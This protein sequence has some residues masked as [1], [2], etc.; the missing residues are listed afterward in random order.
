MQ[1]RRRTELIAQLGEHEARQAKA[2]G[3]DHADLHGAQLTAGVSFHSLQSRAEMDGQITDLLLPNGEAIGLRDDRGGLR[4]TLENLRVLALDISQQRVHD[5]KMILQPH[6]R[7]LQMDVQPVQELLIEAQLR[8]RTAAKGCD[9][10]VDELEDIRLIDPGRE[11]ILRI[12][13]VADLGPLD[14]QQQIGKLN[15][16]H[17]QLKLLLNSSQNALGQFLVLIIGQ[18]QHIAAAVRECALPD[19]FDADD[20]VHHEPHIR[21]LRE[22]LQPHIAE[23]IEQFFHPANRIGIQ[24]IVDAGRCPAHGLPLRRK[25]MDEAP[26]RLAVIGLAARE[27]HAVARLLHNR[28]MALGQPGADLLHIG[29][30]RRLT[31][32]QQAAVYIK[33]LRCAVMQQ[34]KEQPLLPFRLGGKSAGGLPVKAQPQRRHSLGRTCQPQPQPLLAL[35][36]QLP[37]AQLT[38]DI[39]QLPLH[40]PLAAADGI[41]NI[42]LA[43]IVQL[44]Q[45]ELQ[46]LPDTRC[47]FHRISLLP[48]RDSRP[49]L[50]LWPRRSPVRPARTPARP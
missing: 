19:A 36:R 49:A 25:R 18:L 42:L 9:H 20:N 11:H 29:R 24:K 5:G 38:A 48:C 1:L 33:L 23:P 16:R 43:D 27:H 34:L 13:L 50:R 47:D 28:E 3:A 39:L 8:R 30:H 21:G 41:G 14:M 31:H 37:A 6:D 44:F 45:K 32:V 22:A 12:A 46:N 7:R 17:P 40:R 10:T 26:Q 15:L 4:G 35:E 2:R